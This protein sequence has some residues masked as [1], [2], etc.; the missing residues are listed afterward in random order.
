[1]EEM[2]VIER[3]KSFLKYEQNRSPYTVREY[4]HDVTE[5]AEFIT[6]GKPAELDPY[7][8]TTS[9]LRAWLASEAS[10]I[11]PRSMRRKLQS[12]RAFFRFLMKRENLPTNPAA[13]I[14]PAHIP[15][16]LP[17]FIRAEELENV[18]SSK[19]PD[20]EPWMEERNLLIIDI[21]YSC[22]LRRAELA[23]LDDSD[24][25]FNSKEMR[26]VGKR[27][28]TRIIPLPDQLLEKISHWQKT[29]D[30]RWK[31]L[32]SG[33]MPLI[34][35]AQGRISHSA[36]AKITKTMLSGTQGGAVNPHSLRHSFATAML[37]GGADINSVKE[38]LGHSSIATTQIYTHVSFEQ[39]RR[40]YIGAH[41]RARK[42][43]TD[44][45][46]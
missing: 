17:T 46:S 38:F 36:I 19:R 32:P 18:I 45:E 27:N 31:P 29:R 10:H 23:A 3:F 13:D 6:A 2:D 14:Q 21:L 30:K 8:V 26:V 42:K 44:E 22:G 24:I 37:D 15:K 9:D 40:D 28:K 33:E 7:S 25:R 1:M 43:D 41:P 35:S 16:K 12:L 34:R 20:M 11:G 5:F 4:G 39:M